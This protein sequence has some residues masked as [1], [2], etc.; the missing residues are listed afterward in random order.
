MVPGNIILT[1]SLQFYWFGIKGYDII[2]SEYDDSEFDFRELDHGDQALGLS[3]TAA[4]DARLYKFNRT[5]H[6]VM[7]NKLADVFDIERQV[8][9]IED[10]TCA[11]HLCCWAL[12]NCWLNIGNKSS[13]FGMTEL[14]SLSRC[15]F[16]SLVNSLYN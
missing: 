4:F 1:A 12:S 5:T 2:R 15:C 14:H 7:Y 3:T 9:P 8:I 13:K 10:D 6:A 11:I 16:F